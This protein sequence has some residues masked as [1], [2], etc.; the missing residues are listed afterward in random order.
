MDLSLLENAGLTRG[1]IAVYM[2]LFESGPV[3]IGEV[4]RRAKMPK[5]AAYYHLDNLLD[6]GI[7]TYSTVNG[8]KVF[9][10]ESPVRIA[11]YVRKKAEE[12]QRTQKG[13]E[14]LGKEFRDRRIKPDGAISAK[15]FMGWGGLK[16]AFDDILETVPKGEE[17]QLFGVTEMPATKERFRRFMRQFQLKRAAAGVL[18]RIIFPRKMIDT[19]GKDREEEPLSTVKYLK[20]SVGTP[21]FTSIYSDKLLLANWAPPYAFQLRSRELNI[22]MK[23]LFNNSWATGR[24]REQLTG[25]TLPKITL[26][27]SEF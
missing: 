20:E 9:D 10:I 26:K 12:L 14:S 17:Y 24:S 6:R 25:K 1:E 8:S 3:T 27:K 22:A 19:V 2:A 4:V 23:N 21:A 18:V 7:I 11:D 5:S 13:L 16:S 15:V